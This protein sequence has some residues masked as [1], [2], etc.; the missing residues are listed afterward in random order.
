MK[1]QLLVSK[2]DRTFYWVSYVLVA[3]VVIITL[4]PIYFVVVASISDP[5]SVALGKVMFWPDGFTLASY[6]RVFHHRLIW[7]SYG[8]TVIYTVS[9]TVL[10]VIATMTA[11]FVF[12]RKGLIGSRV[13]MFIVLFT[14]YFNGGL[15]PNYFNIK[16]LG[17]YNTMWAVILPGMLSGYFIIIARTYIQ[18]NIP[19]AI[20]EA[21][22]IDGCSQLYYFIRIVLPLSAP[23]I[24]VLALY[25]VV[26]QWNSFFNALIYLSDRN[27]YPLQMILREILI[28]S[29]IKPEDMA[30]SLDASQFVNNVNLKEQ[31]KY[32]LV[33]V[34]SAP[35]LILYPFLQRFFIKG[36]M[37]GSVKG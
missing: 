19:E 5:S 13:C 1:N 4:Y 30:T 9:Y 7:I 12:S 6:Q 35:M 33:I 22:V 25:S 18:T 21:A 37:I 17:L 28:N 27:K 10:S 23:I 36:I 15:V 31:M 11:A 2:S 34:S 26:G 20:N 29:Q 14:M 3:F 32:A 16:A 24:G 8:N